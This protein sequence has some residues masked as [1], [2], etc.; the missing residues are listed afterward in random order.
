MCGVVI[1]DKTM[2]L[3]KP[4]EQ[5]TEADLL[6]LIQLHVAERRTLDYKLTLP[7]N[8]SDDGKEFVADVSSFANTAGGHLIYGMR[9]E[10]GEPVELVGIDGDADAAI[11]RLDNR[12]RDGVA[13]RIPGVHSF[14]VKLASSK[15]AIVIKIPKSFVSPHMVTLGGR[16][17]FYARMSN[18]RYE[19]DVDQIRL[20][21]LNSESI[22]SRIRDFRVD[23]ISHIRSGETPIPLIGGPCI[24]LHI[25]P[26]AGF[27]AGTQYDVLKLEANVNTLR[28]LAPIFQE[29]GEHKRINLDGLVVFPYRTREE[30]TQG[31]TQIYRSGVVEAVDASIFNSSG[32]IESAPR[33]LASQ[34]LEKGLIDAVVR[35]VG[36]LRSLPVDPPLVVMLSLID[37]KG[38]SMALAGLSFHNMTVPFDRNVVM[39][40]ELLIESLDVNI[41]R[42]LKPMLDSLWNVVG[43]RESPYYTNGE[44]TGR[45]G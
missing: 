23:R 25:I 4:T 3:D 34:I 16:S 36:V 2:A 11:L 6:E 31:Y 26:I 15:W 35:F 38:Y 30:K 37:V 21:F 32:F 24:A 40:P 41:P 9:E 18:G 8:S 14:A 19:L 28:T 20:A 42:K 13:P 1:G 43:E 17:K 27:G 7:G 39:I 45:R 44:W 5:I 22:A 12:T 29:F 10:K 33:P